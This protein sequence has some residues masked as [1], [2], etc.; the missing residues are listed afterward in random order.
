M[1]YLGIDFEVKNMPE[2]D[3]G[4]IPLGPWMEAYLK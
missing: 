2:L 1:R 3:P 4:F